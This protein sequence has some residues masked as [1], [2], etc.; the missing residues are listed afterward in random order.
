MFAGSIGACGRW[1]APLG[2]CWAWVGCSLLSLK[3]CVAHPWGLLNTLQMRPTV[4]LVYS[5]YM[6]LKTHLKST[7]LPK[8]S[9]RSWG[10]LVSPCKQ[11]F[12]QPKALWIR[13]RHSSLHQLW[14]NPGFADYLLGSVTHYYCKCVLPVGGVGQF[15]C[16]RMG[17]NPFNKS[18]AFL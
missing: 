3:G 11:D 17:R 12:Y 4:L 5:K 1:E 7:N 13:P 9:S 14:P 8:Y 6:P 16:H 10:I 18:D 15:S 2:P